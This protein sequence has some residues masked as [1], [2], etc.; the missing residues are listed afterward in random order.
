M[1]KQIAKIENWI[2]KR[3]PLEPVNVLH[4]TVDGKEIISLPIKIHNPDFHLCETEDALYL[5]GEPLRT[6]YAEVSF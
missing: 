1:V 3:H 5:L 6:K 4:G 2:V